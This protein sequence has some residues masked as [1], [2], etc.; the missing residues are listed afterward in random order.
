MLSQNRED[1]GFMSCQE[2]GTA[3]ITKSFCHTVPSTFLSPW[4]CAE[5]HKKPLMA[6]YGCNREFQ[7]QKLHQ[8]WTCLCQEKLHNEKRQLV[9][10][11]TTAMSMWGPV[12][13]CLLRLSFGVIFEQHC[14]G[15]RC[16]ATEDNILRAASDPS[17]SSEGNCV[18]N[19]AFACGALS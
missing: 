4:L 11:H 2:G 18:G 7:K 15:P 6:F 9:L 1:Q 17:V 19:F 16:C 8:F 12:S 3:S 14:T 13:S 10:E 5:G